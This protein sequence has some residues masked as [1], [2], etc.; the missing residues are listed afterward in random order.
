M[1]VII[2]LKTCIFC[3][4]TIVKPELHYQNFE[5]SQNNLHITQCEEAL[6]AAR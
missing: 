4:I 1:L 6:A 5:R 3:Q 2:V